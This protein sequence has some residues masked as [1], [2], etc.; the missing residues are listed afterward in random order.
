[1]VRKGRRHQDD[2]RQR[3]RA[4]VVIEPTRKAVSRRDDIAAISGWNA[5]IYVYL[6]ILLAASGTIYFWNLGRAS[7]DDAEA[8]S[9]YI[10]GRPTLSAVIDANLRFDPGKPG[11]YPLMLHYYCRAFGTSKVALRAFSAAFALASVVLV[12]ALAARLFDDAT[13]LAA[14]AIWAFNPV[15]LVLERWARMYSMFIA[16]A[17]ASLLALRL[18]QEKPTVLRTVT[19]GLLGA[20]MLYTHLGAV[21]ILGAEAAL[22]VRDYWCGRSVFAPSLGLLITLILFAPVAPLSFDQIYSSMTGERFAWIG[23]AIELPL[24]IKAV[25]GLAAVSAALVLVFG[26]PRAF[27]RPDAP[28]GA[29]P[30][31]LRW[32]AI[33]VVLPVIVLFAGSILVR[34]MFKLRYLAPMV[35]GIPILVAASLNL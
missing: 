33:W 3:E 8:Y 20:A 6:L 30:E 27:D 34:P 21:C 4:G 18:V 26:P 24:A 16:L 1:M 35:A 31:P 13:A 17:V 23:P 12:F 15:I 29:N 2:R 28:V 11:L 10:A 19:F 25:V 5:R 9:A 7:L 14:S 22:L 32:S